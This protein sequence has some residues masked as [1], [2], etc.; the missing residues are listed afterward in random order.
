VTV[1]FAVLPPETIP[2]PAQLN[3]VPVVVAAERTTAVVVPVS[4]PPV[5]LALGA[6][7]LTL[8]DAV[9]VLVHPVEE[10]VAVTVYVPVALTLGLAVVPPETIPGPAQLNPVPL[11]VAAERTTDVVVH[12]SVPP[13]A[14]A[15]GGVAVEFTSAVAVLVHPF[16]ELLTVTVY[17]PDELTL[18]LAELPPETMPVPAQL[19][20][21]PLVVAAESTTDVVVQVRVPPVALAPGALVFSLTSAVPVLVQPFAELVTV[22]VYVPVELTTGFAVVLPETIPGPAQLNPV[23]LVV[24]A[25]RTTVVLVH[26]SVPPVVL[27]PGGVILE[28]TNAVVA[29]VHPLAEFVIVTVYVPLELTTG[30]APEPPE[31]MP[32]PAQLNPVPLVVVAVR[33][34]EVVVHVNVPPVALAPGAVMLALTSAVAVL[35]QPFEEFVAVTVYVPDAL[36]TGFAVAPPDTMPGPVQLND[37][38]SVVAAERTTDVVVHVNVPPVALAPGA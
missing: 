21:V 23:P 19:K 11:V 2:G 20:L 14:L 38:P 36:T 31:T 24:A 22:T 35:A 29:L 33:T 34:T 6:V 3:P 26:V 12:V 25:E 17:V 32:G 8:T 27:A 28:L 7:V 4:V 5:A 18:G 37:V 1:G 13:V 9:S 15:S 16:A 30:F 10:L